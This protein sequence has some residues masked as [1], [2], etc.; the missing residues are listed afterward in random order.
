MLRDA[1]S[2]ADQFTPDL[3]TFNRNGESVTGYFDESGQWVDFGASPQWAP[4]SGPSTPED[5]ASWREWILF[6]QLPPEEQQRYLMMKRAMQTV[7]TGDA[8]V[9]VDPTNPGGDPLATFAEGLGPDRQTVDDTV[10]TMPSVAGEDLA[11][12]GA[13]TVADIPL[14]PQQAQEKITSGEYMVDLLDRLVSHEG[15]SGVVG[16]PNW[17]D[18]TNAPGT[19]EASFRVLKDQI[20]GN[21][22]LQAY[23]Q[24]KGGGTITENE[25]EQA[26]KA[27]ARLGE[28]QGEEDF[29]A[30]A[31]EFKAIIQ[32][33]VDKVRNGQVSADNTPSGG[34]PP[35]PEGVPAN[36]R[37]SPSQDKWWWETSPGVWESN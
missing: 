2:G 8:T 13:P 16:M 6:S 23:E 37:Y 3:Q 27:L 35:M 30:A 22:F 31:N 12:G 28:A 24:L 17:R 10:V 33:A 29:I 5:P 26:T 34:P 14:S 25:T 1:V 9:V 15:L 11:G 20:E 7:D 21:I 32:R 4:Q 18:L 19:P 36:A